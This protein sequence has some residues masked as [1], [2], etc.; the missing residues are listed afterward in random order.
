MRQCK[1]TGDSLAG[2]AE[3][4]VR[5]MCTA[6]RLPTSI[7]AVDQFEER[8]FLDQACS[9][10]IYGTEMHGWTT[11]HGK[12]VEDC[13]LQDA[14]ASDRLLLVGIDQESIRWALFAHI[15]GIITSEHRARPKCEAIVMIA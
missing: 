5:H 9:R 2:T 14:L 13:I 12:M 4:W 3:N 11:V 1:I 10:L 6:A 7:P 8:E 15:P